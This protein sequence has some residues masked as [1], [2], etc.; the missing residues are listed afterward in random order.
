MP[1]LSYDESFWNAQLHKQEA[2]KSLKSVEL[3]EFKGARHQM[4]FTSFIL[5]KALALESFSISWLKDDTLN[6]YDNVRTIDKV[7]QFQKTST[8]A[9]VISRSSRKTPSIL[10]FI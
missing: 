4:R 9:R 7:M 1:V 3:S 2:F 10:L 6:S 8:K 5:F